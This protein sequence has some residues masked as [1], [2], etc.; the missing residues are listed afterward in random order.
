MR[1][2]IIITAQGGSITEV[3]GFAEAYAAY[4]FHQERCLQLGVDPESE[5]ESDDFCQLHEVF[6]D[7]LYD[8]S[9]R[10]RRLYI[11]ELQQ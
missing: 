2:F 10:A 6:I 3:R 8:P 9:V 11:G 5:E 1:F 7:D 4:T